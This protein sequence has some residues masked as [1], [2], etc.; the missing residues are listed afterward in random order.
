MK[1]VE[2]WRDYQLALAKYGDTE[3]TH[4]LLFDLLKAICVS[5]LQ[6]AKLEFVFERLH[7]R[8]WL[9]AARHPPRLHIGELEC[10]ILED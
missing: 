7:D 1:V 2:L 8:A 4:G 6:P 3:Y 5:L 10:S 9:D